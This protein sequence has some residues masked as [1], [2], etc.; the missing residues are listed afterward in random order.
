[1]QN[2]MTVSGGSGG[3]TLNAKR[4]IVFIVGMGS[5]KE[6]GIRKTQLAVESFLNDKYGSFCLVDKPDKWCLWVEY[7]LHPQVGAGPTF[8]SE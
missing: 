7:D 5:H 8:L 3:T 1:M 4:H 6:G 2:E